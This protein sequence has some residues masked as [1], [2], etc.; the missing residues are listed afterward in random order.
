[1]FVARKADVLMFAD[2]TEAVAEIKAG[3]MVVVVIVY[4]FKVYIE[5]CVCTNQRLS[6]L[7]PSI[8]QFR[9]QIRVLKGGRFCTQ[10][11]KRANKREFSR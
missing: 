6:D 5:R 4:V 1:M 9:P 8:S 7:S 10:N 2:V 11:G 3:R